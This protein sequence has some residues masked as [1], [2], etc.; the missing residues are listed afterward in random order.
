MTEALIYVAL[1]AICIVGAGEAHEAGSPF[2]DTI[3]VIFGVVFLPLI[4][5]S[6]LAMKASEALKGRP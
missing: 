4:V 6:L 1:Y 5:V 3:L 2:P